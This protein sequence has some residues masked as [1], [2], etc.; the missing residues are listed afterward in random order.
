M[1]A[2]VA[3]KGEPDDKS[4]IAKSNQTTKSNQN[5]MKQDAKNFG[6]IFSKNC[7]SCCQ[8]PKIWRK[9]TQFHQNKLFRTNQGNLY[10]E[11]NG[12]LVDKGESQS[13][14]SLE[15]MQKMQSGLLESKGS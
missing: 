15:I 1:T 6:N 8:D 3:R 2:H 4:N 5:Y 7:R 9:E 12:K 10:D 14:L 11:L 13:G